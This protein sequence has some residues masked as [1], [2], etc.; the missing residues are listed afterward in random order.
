MTQ[1]NAM[2]SES[3][4]I[5]N[6]RPAQYGISLLAIVAVILMSPG[7]Q[8]SLVFIKSAACP[9]FF[10]AV[11]GLHLIFTSKAA[12]QPWTAVFI[13]HNLL[14]ALLFSCWLTIVL[15]TPDHSLARVAAGFCTSFAIYGGLSIAFESFFGRRR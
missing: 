10:F 4:A 5:W 6:S 15:W 8:P 9:L 1:E 3:P 2:D 12:K 11:R 7:D 13:E 14:N